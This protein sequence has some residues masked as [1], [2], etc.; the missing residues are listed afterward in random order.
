MNN[1][2]VKIG[3]QALQIYYDEAFSSIDRQIRDII[4]QN[5]YQM[6][7]KRLKRVVVDV[8][9]CIGMFSYYAYDWADL[10]YAIEPAKVNYDCL[11]E[12][13]KN[14]DL[15]KIKT[16]KLAP[17]DGMGYM[18]NTS[19]TTKESDVDSKTLNT[20]LNDEKIDH[21]DI[22]KMDVEGSEGLI[23]TS[24]DIKEATDKISTIIMENHVGGALDSVYE[25]L[26]YKIEKD[27]VH[28]LLYR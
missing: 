16:Y 13:V 19:F 14:N 10:I 7:F 11:V 3:S 23:F 24:S 15:D 6:P 21:V 27:G 2:V 4:E 8:G 5:E 9:A 12:T 1:K 20:F 22:L 28:Y 26:G 18:V 25:K 17:T